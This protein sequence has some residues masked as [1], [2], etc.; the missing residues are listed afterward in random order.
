MV[1]SGDNVILFVIGLTGDDG[2]SNGMDLALVSAMS[3]LACSLNLV[4]RSFF[5]AKKKKMF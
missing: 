5:E 2:D 4:C 3:R 1:L